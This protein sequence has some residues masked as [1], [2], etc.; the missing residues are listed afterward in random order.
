MKKMIMLLLF[1]ISISLFATY[2]DPHGRY[3]GNKTDIYLNFETQ[4]NRKPNGFDLYIYK[5]SSQANTSCAVDMVIFYYDKTIQ[6]KD[7]YDESDSR[8]WEEKNNKGYTLLTG[9]I[10]RIP[11]WIGELIFDKKRIK[12]FSSY[13]GELQKT[14]KITP[15]MWIDESEYYLN[16]GKTL[17]LETPV[18]SQNTLP[19]VIRDIRAFGSAEYPVFNGE[20]EDGLGEFIP[21]YKQP[22][23][24]VFKAVGPVPKV[25][26]AEEEA[27]I[28]LNLFREFYQEKWIKDQA[29]FQELYSKLSLFT[30][31]IVDKKTAEAK[32]YLNDFL[33]L[34]EKNKTAFAFQGAYM[35][36]K[37]RGEYFLKMIN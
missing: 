15:W 11:N 32:K 27:E 19:G 8:I 20:D 1:L 4:I 33:L 25:D 28:T 6:P 18:S 24:K 23:Y 22:K 21:G 26:S 17:S 14:R 30:D 2:Q 16:P 10:N 34:L 37:I 31:R 7:F 12:W 36:F 13:V 5:I 35:T 9:A 3:W 29:V